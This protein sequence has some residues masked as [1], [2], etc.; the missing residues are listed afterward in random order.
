M[1]KGEG[2]REGDE[3]PGLVGPELERPAV[4]G[5]G[6]G[7]AALRHQGIAPPVR[8]VREV[9]DLAD[10]GLPG[11]IAT[12]QLEVGRGVGHDLQHQVRHLVRGP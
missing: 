12:E 10:L 2:P 7:N 6:V 4:R 11:E 5:D 8:V 1:L 3:H 9:L